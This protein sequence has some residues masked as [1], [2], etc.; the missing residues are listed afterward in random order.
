MNRYFWIF[1]GFILIS[2][3][4][5]AAVFFSDKADFLAG[6][7]VGQ[8]IDFE[9]PFP[10]PS[11][12]FT[13]G[14]ATFSSIESIRPFNEPDD[15]RLTRIGPGRFGNSTTRI[16]ALDFGGISIALAS[17]HKALGFDV[18]TLFVGLTRGLFDVYDVAGTLLDTQ[19]VDS[20]GF[21]GNSPDFI[22]WTNASGIGR[23]EF[24]FF[25]PVFNKEAIDN[26]ILDQASVPEPAFWLLLSIGLIGFKLQL[27]KKRV[28]NKPQAM[29]F[30]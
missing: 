13:L 11:L 30:R 27:K 29:V 6:I 14:D 2:P 15:R 26:V 18:G 28:V 5:N 21:L 17:G 4:S 9:S 7:N 8:V 3:A 22:G 20:V 24:S 16:A 25:G 12:S 23:I 10:T 19:E 1:L